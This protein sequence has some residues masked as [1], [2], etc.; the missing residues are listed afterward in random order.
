MRIVRRVL[1][2][3]LAVYVVA[4]IA[5]SAI[6]QFSSNTELSRT[7]INARYG[8]LIVHYDPDFD[9]LAILSPFCNHPDIFL[10][11]VDFTDGIEFYTDGFDFFGDF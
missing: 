2:I 9:S 1:L 5:A 10:L 6:F 11:V 7:V 8:L 3:L 4:S